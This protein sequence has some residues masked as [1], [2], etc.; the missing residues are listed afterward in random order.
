M[1]VKCNSDKTQPVQKGDDSI[2]NIFS[3]IKWLRLQ[4]CISKKHALLVVYVFGR[5]FIPLELK[6]EL[7]LKNMKLKDFNENSDCEF[8]LSYTIRVHHWSQLNMCV[9]STACGYYFYFYLLIIFFKTN[10]VVSLSQDMDK[11]PITK[12]QSRTCLKHHD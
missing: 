6:Y 2:G 10:L 5:M 1:G 7:C 4:I 3:H 9:H 11:A 12:H 8:R